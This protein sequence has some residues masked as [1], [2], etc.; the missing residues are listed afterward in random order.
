MI[1]ILIFR[2][3]KGGWLLIMGLHYLQRSCRIVIAHQPAFKPQTLNPNPKPSILN[4]SPT[5][6]F[7]SLIPSPSGANTWTAY[8]LACWV[9]WGNGKEIANYYVY[10]GYTV[11]A[12]AFA[13][14]CLA[15]RLHNNRGRFEHGL[16]F[17]L[18]LIPI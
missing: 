11:M 3:L 16:C 8:D 10:W 12:L 7:Q 2:P 13:F 1:R 14:R 4:P 15:C 9:I 18:P 5:P 6:Y 17:L